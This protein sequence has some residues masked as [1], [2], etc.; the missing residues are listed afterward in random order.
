MVTKKPLIMRLRGAPRGEGLCC[1]GL[2]NCEDMLLSDP[3]EKYSLEK[4]IFWLFIQWK[5]LLKL[6]MWDGTET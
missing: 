3:L 1:N 2:I 4:V 6:S 5:K